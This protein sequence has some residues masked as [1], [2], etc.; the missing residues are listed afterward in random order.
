MEISF[1]LLVNPDVTLECLVANIKYFVIV[2]ATLLADTFKKNN[3]LKEFVLTRHDYQWISESVFEYVS[4]N[5]S[6]LNSTFDSNHTLNKL[7]FG[8]R[9]YFLAA[10]VYQV[11]ELNSSS[12]KAWLHRG[13]HLQPI[14]V[15]FAYFYWMEWSLLYWYM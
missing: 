10:H 7:F 3:R 14:G 6:S 12:N 9:S 2:M 13:K 1:A 8:Y 15:I 11:L 4:C 5:K